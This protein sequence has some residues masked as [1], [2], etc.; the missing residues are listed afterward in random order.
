MEFSRLAI[1]TFMISGISAAQDVDRRITAEVKDFS[2]AVSLFAKNLSTGATFEIAG[3]RRVRTAS[4]IKLAIMAAAFADVA[5]GH[6]A[7][8]D[9]LILDWSRW[10][11]APR[12]ARPHESDPSQS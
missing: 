3:Q 5:R 2:G 6:A 1:A 9:R 11:A 4:T 7:W 12:N 8:T 10:A